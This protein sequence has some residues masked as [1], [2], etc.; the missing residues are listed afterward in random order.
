MELESTRHERR[1]SLDKATQE[2]YDGEAASSGAI[3]SSAVEPLV[4]SR[5]TTSATVDATVTELYF[6]IA[7][8]NAIFADLQLNCSTISEGS[9]APHRK[10]TT[11]FSKQHGKNSY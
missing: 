5:E 7:A 10:L 9:E 2:V 1:R 4:T 6:L 11:D 8:R 3:F